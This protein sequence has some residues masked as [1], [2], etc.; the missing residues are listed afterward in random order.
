[1]RF[2]VSIEFEAPN[3]KE[4]MD[5][6]KDCLHVINLAPKRTTFTTESSITQ[7]SGEESSNE[8]HSKATS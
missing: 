6:F 2:K 3:Q 4:A 7:I 8:A 5:A 1:M